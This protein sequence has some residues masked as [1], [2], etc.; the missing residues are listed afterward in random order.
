MSRRLFQLFQLILIT[1]MLKYAIARIQ[2]KILSVH[3]RDLPIYLY[4][5]CIVINLHRVLMV[6]VRYV[7]TLVSLVLWWLYTSHSRL[8][9]S[10][11]QHIL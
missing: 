1:I 6:S 2:H 3:F 5:L 8:V 7:S 9:Q 4:Y 11:Q 10:R